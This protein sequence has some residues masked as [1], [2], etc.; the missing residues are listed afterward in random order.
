MIG[1]L[2]NRASEPMGNEKKAR[3]VSI[4][5]RLGPFSEMVIMTNHSSSL[6]HWEQVIWRSPR[7]K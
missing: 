5:T 4:V 7:E 2:E 6:V 3:R 1:A